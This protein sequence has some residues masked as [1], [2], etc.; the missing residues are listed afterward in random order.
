[1]P[2]HGRI[3]KID[4]GTFPLNYPKFVLP[5]SANFDKS[6]L[7]PKSD[8]AQFNDELSWQDAVEEAGKWIGSLRLGRNLDGKTIDLTEPA[9]MLEF[10][11]KFREMVLESARRK[12]KKRGARE[13]ILPPPM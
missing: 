1:M 5:D 12:L 8:E 3:F 7:N 4:R 13:V 9:K 11:G 2:T 10:E 6:H